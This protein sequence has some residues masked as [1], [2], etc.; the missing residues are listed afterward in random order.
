MRQSVRQKEHPIVSNLNS[1]VSEIVK[2]EHD[3]D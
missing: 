2:N 1:S 3:A